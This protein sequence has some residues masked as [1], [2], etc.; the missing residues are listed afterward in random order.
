MWRSWGEKVGAVPA[1][2]PAT[3]QCLHDVCPHRGAPLHKV[4]LP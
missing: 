2:A 4:G 3:I 1:T